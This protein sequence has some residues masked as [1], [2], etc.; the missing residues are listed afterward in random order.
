MS[1]VF[2]ALQLQRSMS[3]MSVDAARMNIENGQPAEDGTPI[4]ETAT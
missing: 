1:L 3:R 2:K 4:N